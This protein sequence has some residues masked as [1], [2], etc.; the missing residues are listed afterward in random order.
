MKRILIAIAATILLGTGITL[1]ESYQYGSSG[2]SSGD[3]AEFQRR[4]AQAL[5]NGGVTSTAVTNGVVVET[6]A[7]MIDGMINTYTKSTYPDGSIKFVS[8]VARATTPNPGG[9]GTSGPS[10][11]SGTPV[12][13]PGTKPGDTTTPG[14]SPSTKGVLISS[15]TG[16]QGCNSGLIVLN[17]GA[18]RCKSV[19]YVSDGGTVANP[20]SGTTPTKTIVTPGDSTAAA[21]PTLT[22]RANNSSGGYSGGKNYGFMGADGKLH[23]GPYDSSP[24]CSNCSQINTTYDKD[25]ADEAKR[26]AEENNRPGGGGGNNG[27]GSGGGGGGGYGNGGGGRDTPGSSDPGCRNC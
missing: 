2:T 24:E 12:V 11:N 10:G 7:V 22:E 13:I 1:A 3:Y 16:I 6:T 17:N 25:A 19:T 21:G 5:A 20:T 23:S 27:G 14:T 26:V 15:T 4:V 9:T 8:T 18:Y